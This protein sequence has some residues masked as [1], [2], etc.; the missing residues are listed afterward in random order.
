Q[1]IT[2]TA[3]QED[4]TPWA[5]PT[6]PKRVTLPAGGALRTTVGELFGFASNVLSTGWIQISAPQGFIAAYIGYGNSLTPSFAL[7]EATRTEDASRY[8]VF[9]HVAEGS[10]FYTGITLVN[11]GTQAADIEFY[12]LRPDGSTI[13]RATLTLGPNQK[14]A[15]LFRE[16]LPASLSQVG[17][18]GF[19]RSSTPIVGAVLFGSSNGSAL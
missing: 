3:F 15:E 17:G 16:L 19:L 13:G 18:W 7:V 8:A 1:E 4:G 11:P 5:V 12:T 14:T 10:G 9:S 6:N 2:L